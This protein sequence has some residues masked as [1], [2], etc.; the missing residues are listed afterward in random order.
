VPLPGV[1]GVT[2]HRGFLEAFECCREEIEAAVGAQVPS[3]LGLYIT[4]HSLGGALAQIASAVLERDNLAAC[5]TFGSPR[6]GT[7]GF[8]RQVKCPHYRIIN[9]WDL[10]P[11]V[12]PPWFRGYCHTG[13]PR[14]LT[15]GT[16][17]QEALRR[18]RSAA[19]RFFV[20]VV[21]LILGLI[22]RRPILTL[23]SD[24]SGR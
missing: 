12:P 19:T 13:D 20:D 18:D 14:L 4:G 9:D 5:Y 1:P 11:G 7:L 2:V 23:L 16:R 6:V 15:P 24:E 17:G 3:T 10:V 22:S 21:A 8:D